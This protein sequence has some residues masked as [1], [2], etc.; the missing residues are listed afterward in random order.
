MSLKWRVLF[1][2]ALA[3]L[4]AMSLWFSASA[5]APTLTTAWNP[6]DNGRAWL[7]MSVQIGFVAGAFLSA[8]F[9]RADIFPTH[10]IFFVG[11][12][13][14]ALANFLIPLAANDLAL[15]LPLQM[16]LGFLLTLVSIRL[17]P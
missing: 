3:E 6:D 1:I 12:L 15:A 11:A 10:I 14:G 16:S 8:F 13:L 17:I 4:F 2:L 5:V 9:N 7:T